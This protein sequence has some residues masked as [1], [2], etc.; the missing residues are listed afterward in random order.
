MNVTAIIGSVD[1]DAKEGGNVRRIKV[2]RVVVHHKYVDYYKQQLEDKKRLDS[3]K[4]QLMEWE[5]SGR[6]IDD[7]FMAKVEKY[8]Y[9]LKWLGAAYIYDNMYYYDIALLKLKD[10]IVPVF[11]ESH[12]L[13]N[14]FTEDWNR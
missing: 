1:R 9:E 7:E 13:I 5:F 8:K 4:R 3:I 6:D 14:L 10:R 11:N 2:E 12:Y